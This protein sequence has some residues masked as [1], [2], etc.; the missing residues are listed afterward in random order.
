MN[1]SLFFD[2]DT[3]NLN[4]SK[5]ELQKRLGVKRDFDLTAI[6][7]QTQRVKR[8]ISARCCYNICDVSFDD[9][10]LDFGFF[11]TNS[12]A[13]TKLGENCQKA[14]FFAVTLGFELERE[15]TRLSHFS[16]ADAFLTDAI[17]S[18]YA[19]CVCDKA[20]KQIK[21]ILG[22]DFDYSKRFSPGYSDFELIHQKDVLSFVDA[23]AHLGIILLDSLLMIPQK[24]ITAV[25][26]F[27]KK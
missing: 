11:K 17:A 18:A 19:E 27:D 7:K 2:I 26:F 24:S 6:K 12:K 8:L 16:K 13:L 3:E 20:E 15:Q 21:E 10:T 23:K 5:P 1:K 22:K 25:M 4:I 14:V 9:S